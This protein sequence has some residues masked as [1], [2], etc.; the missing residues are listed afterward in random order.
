MTATEGRRPEANLRATASFWK[1]NEEA[2][3]RGFDRNWK[4][5]AC[6]S[7]PVTATKGRRPGVNLRP[8]A[9]EASANVNSIM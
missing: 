5:P 1:G 9:P 3:G 6:W 4:G 7:F 8:A 2:S